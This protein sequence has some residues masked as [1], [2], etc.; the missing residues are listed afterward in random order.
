M[1][2]WRLISVASISLLLFQLSSERLLSV[3]DKILVAFGIDKGCQT[4]C[5][6]LRVLSF[7]IEVA[8]VRAEEVVARQ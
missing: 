7:Q 1:T 5:F 3:R 8:A 6:P 4:P 2:G